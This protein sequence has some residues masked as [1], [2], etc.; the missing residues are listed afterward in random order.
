MTDWQPIETAPRDGARVLIYPG[1]EEPMSVG[2]FDAGWKKRW[3]SL[4]GEV[5]GGCDC[6]GSGCTH[7]DASPTHWMPLPQPPTT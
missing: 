1:A 4:E 2:Y 3:L 7:A 6:C 5:W